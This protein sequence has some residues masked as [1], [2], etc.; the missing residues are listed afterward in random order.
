MY[1]SALSENSKKNVKKRVKDNRKMS[2]DAMNT[3]VSIA[4]F[5]ML[6]YNKE[7]ETLFERSLQSTLKQD[8]QSEKFGC[9]MEGLHVRIGSKIHVRTFYEAELL[10]HNNY[11]TSR[12]AYWLFHELMNHKGLNKKKRFILRISATKIL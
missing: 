11:Y 9:K 4:P 7:K 12:F 3:N 1:T 6:E 10:F 2:A 8:V 5:D